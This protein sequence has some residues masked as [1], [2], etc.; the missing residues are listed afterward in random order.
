MATRVMVL[1]VG[2]G[3]FLRIND[4]FQIFII[5]LKNIRPFFVVEILS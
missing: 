5:E 3:V 1:K 2:E 4:I